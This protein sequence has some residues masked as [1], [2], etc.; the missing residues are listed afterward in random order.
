MGKKARR[1]KKFTYRGVE[2]DK[3]LDLSNTELMELMCAHQ[4]RKFSRG[5]SR[6]PTTLLKKLRVAKQG[7][8]YGEK[9]PAVKT[10][11][12]NMVIVPEMVGSI[13]AIYNGKTFVSA[14]SSPR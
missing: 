9:P 2:L 10:H 11:L 5:I 6:A 3:L 7:V 13:V 14:R 4:R 1:A 12:R 8:P